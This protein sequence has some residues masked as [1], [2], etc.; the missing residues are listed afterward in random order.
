[1]PLVAKAPLQ[2]PAAAH[3]VAFDEPQVKTAVPPAATE[4]VLAVSV[5]AGT[6]LTVML[7]GLLEPPG[8]VQV[9]E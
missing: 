6:T 9:S 8:P 3:E 1:V 4:V 7:E 5:T 2:P